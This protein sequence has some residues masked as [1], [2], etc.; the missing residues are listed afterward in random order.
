MCIRDRYLEILKLIKF[1]L[2]QLL[3]HLSSLD[4]QITVNNIISI[5]MPRTIASPNYKIQVASD[6]FIVSLGK[7]SL[8]GP[9]IIV[10][11]VF[12]LLDKLAAES[13]AYHKALRMS[14]T[15]SGFGK[16]VGSAFDQGQNTAAVVRYLGIVNI[17]LTHYKTA[18]ANSK[19]AVEFFS[20]S[21]VNLFTAYPDKCQIK[22]AVSQYSRDIRTV[23]PKAFEATLSKRSSEDREKLEE[24][25]NAAPGEFEEK[26]LGPRENIWGRGNQSK[27]GAN[28]KEGS[29]SKSTLPNVHV[30]NRTAT[31]PKEEQKQGRN[32]PS[33]SRRMGRMGESIENLK[34]GQMIMESNKVPPVLPP[35]VLKKTQQPVESKREKPNWLEDNDDSFEKKDEME[36]TYKENTATSFGFR[37]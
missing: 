28:A 27:A 23:N 25:L 29:E 4:L 3:K 7:D 17:M 21:A 8:I 9:I 26:H 34:K 35:L 14:G 2:N 13:V 22:E 36:R 31:L 32:L 24:V 33:F 1:S 10:K 19:E 16:Q 6:K 18:I 37:K 30:N 20:D 5:L 12:R 15:Q 11:N